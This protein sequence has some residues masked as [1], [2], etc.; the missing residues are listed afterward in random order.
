MGMFASVRGWVELMH[1]QRAAAEHVIQ[2]NR[3]DLYSG[4]WAFPAE[5]FN[6]SLYVF[7]GGDVRGHEVPWLRSQVEQLAAFPPDEDGDRPR[8][9]FVVTDERGG[10]ETWQ[11]R[12]GEVTVYPAPEYAW[13]A[14]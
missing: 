2:R 12:D 14:E 1:D 8:G 5:P 10:A 6:W 11:V 13:L 3:H 7:Y 9:L 4:G